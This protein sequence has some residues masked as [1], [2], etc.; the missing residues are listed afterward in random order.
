MNG[1]NESKMDGVVS[2]G[3]LLTGGR[4][5]RMGFDKALIRIGNRTLAQRTGSILT[6]VC[7][8]VLEVGPGYSDLPAV[9]E[10]Q[11]GQGPLAA[12]AAGWAALKGTKWE[13]PVIVVAT[14]LPLLSE[15]VL[16]WIADHPAPGTVVPVVDGRAQPLC[17]R[18]SPEVLER[19][20]DLVDAGER[21]VMALVDGAGVTQVDAGVLSAGLQDADTPADLD[22]LGLRA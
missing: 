7:P 21:S 5:R 8:F 17:A 4:S 9:H 2:A 6:T 10:V 22:R 16:H 3:L 12:I 15:Q 19:A 14:D 20:V 18:Y 11:P 13:G 1:S